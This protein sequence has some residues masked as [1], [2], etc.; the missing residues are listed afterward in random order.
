MVRWE[1]ALLDELGFGLD[2]AACAATGGKENLIYVSPKS[3]RAVS[4]EAGEEYK[5]RLLRLPPFLARRQSDGA[6]PDDIRDGLTLTG[7]FME[8]RVLNPREEAM[9]AARVRFRDLIE[10]RTSALD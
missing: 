10:R 3:G 5:D 2:L 1:M 6:T 8:S 4:A 7:H 9:P